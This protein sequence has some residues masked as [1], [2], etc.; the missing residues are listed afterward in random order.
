MGVASPCHHGQ[1]EGRGLQKGGIDANGVPGS[2]RSR[3]VV[4]V[5]LGPLKISSMDTYFCSACKVFVEMAA[6][7]EFWNFAKLKFG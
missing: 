1:G 5:G 7:K 4:R 6:R 3:E 2:Q